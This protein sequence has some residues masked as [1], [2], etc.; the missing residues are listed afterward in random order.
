MIS[1]KR[2]NP[3]RRASSLRGAS[4]GENLTDYWGGGDFNYQ[5]NIEKDDRFK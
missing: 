2:I 5:D 1:V 3:L 4:S